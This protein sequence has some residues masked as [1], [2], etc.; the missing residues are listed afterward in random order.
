M[1]EDF[2][3]GDAE[4]IIRALELKRHPE[5]GWFRES[6]RDH[7]STAIYYLLRETEGSHWHRIAHSETWHF[8]AGAPLELRLSVD[9]AASERHLLGTDIARGERPQLVVPPRC[10]Q[11]ARS[12]GAWSLS[13]CTVAPPF[14]FAG[15]ELAPKDWRPGA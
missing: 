11:A 3:A 7:A 1:M 12:L 9:G 5:G 15:F 14:D 13:G 4:A 6:F 2:R 10:W 8:Y